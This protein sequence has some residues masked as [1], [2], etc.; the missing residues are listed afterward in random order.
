MNFLFYQAIHRIPLGIAVALEFMGPLGLSVLKSHRWLDILW[1]IFAALGVILL[2]PLSSHQGNQGLD[3]MGL[4]FALL[5]GICWAIYILMSAR[6][7]RILPGIQG[8]IWAL[9][10]GGLIL[11]PVGILKA[12]SALF[13]VKI[14]AIS[15]GV[16]LLSSA[17]PYALELLAL[18]RLPVNVFGV[19][20]SLEPMAAAIAGFWILGET[21][22]LQAMVAILLISVAAG[23]AARFRAA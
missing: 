5:A 18:K 16:A 11:A 8:L 13:N 1:V 20:L 3:Q 2:G 21:I 15:S 6:I 12:G 10:L 23:G 7:G 9:A 4:V 17:I 14:L 22:T 19:L